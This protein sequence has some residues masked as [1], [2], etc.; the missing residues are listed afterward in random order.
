MTVKK[1]KLREVLFN[2]SKSLRE[3]RNLNERKFVLGKRHFSRKRKQMLF[4][5]LVVHALVFLY[6]IS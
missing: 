1:R 3:K 6:F 5:C 4:V 2:T